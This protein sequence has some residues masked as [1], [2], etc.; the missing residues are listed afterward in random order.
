MC[1]KRRRLRALVSDRLSA[2]ADEICA[3][4]ETI[5]AEYEE[6]LRRSR[7]ENQRNQKNQRNPELL[8]P[9]LRPQVRLHRTEDVHIKTEKPE[10]DRSP[11]PP[12]ARSLVPPQTQLPE[13]P[14]EPED[15]SPDWEPRVGE[16]RAGG[17]AQLLHSDEE[18]DECNRVH[19]VSAE[20][21]R[22]TR[23]NAKCDGEGKRKHECPICQKK[24]GRKQELKRHMLLHTGEK[25]FSCPVCEKRFIQKSNLKSHIVT[26]LDSVDTIIRHQK[27]SEASGEDRGGGEG[28]EEDE[29]RGADDDKLM[30]QLSD[31]ENDEDWPRVMEGPCSSSAQQDE[32]DGGTL[33]RLSFLLN[34]A[35]NES[36]ERGQTTVYQCPICD[37]VF[38]RMENLRRHILV[39]TGEKAFSCPVC[40]KQF[41]LKQHLKLHMVLH[42][43][44]K[45]F[46]CSV[47]SKT[48]IRKDNLRSHMRI[49]SADRPFGCSECGA[50]FFSGADLERHTSV[51]TAERP[52]VCS[53]CNANFLTR[54]HLTRHEKIHKKETQKPD[55]G[56]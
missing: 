50:R 49:H 18:T 52:F 21:P 46:S 30:E 9:T 12:D 55:G 19:D 54:R 40:N 16:P 25:P 32:G 20:T 47:C 11:D 27:A 26:H 37:K 2:A 35:L 15:W 29:W 13:E 31:S 45:Q 53:V 6:E 51:H 34:Q 5:I 28:A 7:E 10:P 22:T 8:D 42:T 43:R 23:T 3:L 44:D 38:G 41:T 24:L 56:V 48:F 36:K 4:L 33:E 1:E 14:E 39:H 17:S